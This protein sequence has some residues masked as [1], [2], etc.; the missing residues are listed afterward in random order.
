MK[1]DF[2]KAID[3]CDLHGAAPNSLSMLRFNKSIPEYVFKM[4]SKGKDLYIDKN[5]FTRRKKF[6]KKC[7]LNAHDNYFKL[8]ENKSERK[9]ATLLHSLNNQISINSWA[10]FL[11][12]DL[13]RLQQENIFLCNPTKKLYLFLRY[14]NWILQRLSKC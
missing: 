5:Y 3:F 8:T 4:R 9:L 7:W 1:Q 14:S 2:V 13:F 12:Q 11:A 10:T 6:A